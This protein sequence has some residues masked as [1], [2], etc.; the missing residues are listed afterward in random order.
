MSDLFAPCALIPAYRAEATV[1]DVVRGSLRHV[2]RVL[3]VDD[4][5]P[6]R[7]SEAGRE[8]GAEVL[9]LDVNGGKGT[10]LRAGLDRLLARGDPASAPTHVALLDADGQH[11]P[12]DLP[13]LLEAARTGDPFVIGS[14]MDEAASI[15]AYR[16]RTNE[17]GS[18]ILSRMTGL[19]IQDA[20]SGYR[21]VDADLLRQLSL[22]ARGY[23]IETEMLLKAAPHLRRFRHVPVRAIYGGPSHYRPFRDTWLISWGAVYYKVFEID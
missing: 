19:E 11:D 22:N 18:R 16:H 21:V 15:P 5:S 17:I 3:V 13:R 12:D 6:D 7:T 4:G 14:R 23:I 20:Q 9:R 10:A 8:A 2:P 1:G